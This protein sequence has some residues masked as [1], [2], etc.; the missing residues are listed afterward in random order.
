MMDCAVRFSASPRIPRSLA[1]S[2]SSTA[3]C[4]GRIRAQRLDLRDTRHRALRAID[5]NTMLLAPA[6]WVSTTTYFTGSIVSDG[7]PAR[8]GSPASR[9][10]SATSRSSTSMGSVFRAADGLAVRFHQSYFA[11]ELVYTAA[12][13]GTNRVYLSLQS[14]N[15]DVP[16]TA[17][18]WSATVTYLQHPQV[19]TYLSVSYMSLIDLNTQPDPSARPRRGRRPPPT[20]G[21]VYSTDGRPDLFLDR[22]RNL[23]HDPATDRRRELDQHRRAV[24]VDDAVR[25]RRRLGNGWRSAAP[26]SRPASA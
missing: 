5:G 26:N 8:T 20:I 12:G 19:V 22:R 17:T 11:G 24:P 9:T 14:G 13:D 3:N 18:A 25:R 21:Q 15:A 16:A 2:A 7:S 1:R 10:T 23:N 4:A 6:L